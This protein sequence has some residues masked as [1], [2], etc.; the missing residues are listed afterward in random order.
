MCSPDGATLAFASDREGSFDVYVMP[1]SGGRPTRLTFAPARDLPQAFS[2]DGEPVDISEFS[3]HPASLTRQQI[4]GQAATQ[5]L[6]IANAQ[7]QTV[8]ALLG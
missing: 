2:A 1:A 5:V 8:L 4:L 6:A 3:S 7:P